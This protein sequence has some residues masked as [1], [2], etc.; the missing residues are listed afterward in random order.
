MNVYSVTQIKCGELMEIVAKSF[1]EAYYKLTHKY[2]IPFKQ[3][4]KIELLVKNWCE[5]N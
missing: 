3:G 2:E 4:M 5:R 1:E